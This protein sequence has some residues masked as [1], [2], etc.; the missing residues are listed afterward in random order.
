VIDSSPDQ[1]GSDGP[2][3]AAAFGTREQGSFACDCY[4]T[5]L[6]LHAVYIEFESAIFEAAAEA[7]L[8][9]CRAERKSA[10]GAAA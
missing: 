7:L 8:M 4:R 10:P 1:C 9:V 5:D 3:L 6:P 2:T